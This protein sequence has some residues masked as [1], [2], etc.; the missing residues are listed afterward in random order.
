M[1]KSGKMVIIS[2]LTLGG[3]AASWMLYTSRFVDPK[4]AKPIIIAVSQTPL[5][6]PFL[7]ANDKQLFQKYG[8]DVV[9]QSCMGGIA[10]AQLLFEGQTDL[11]TASESVVMFESFMH[12]DIRLITSFVESDNDLKLLALNS[13]DIHE[14]DDL[15]EKRVGVV[16]GSA[17][18]FYFDSL[19]IAHNASDLNYTKIYMQPQDLLSALLS[20]KVDAISIWEPYGYKAMI[21]SKSEINNLG[22]QGIY[23]LSFNLIS[24]EK[25]IVQKEKELINLLLALQEAILWINSNPQESQALIAKSLDV[26]PNQLKWSWKDYLFRLS[27]GNVLLSNLQMQAR[28]ASEKG[29]VSGLTPD[30]RTVFYPLPLEQALNTRVQVK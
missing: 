18:E 11:A 9:L 17:S 3:V 19:L 12:R 5:S 7:V 23:Q 6:A 24:I 13:Q 25:N 29:L 20:F 2:L 16:E 1:V 15:R 4:L 26:P 21:S 27:L 28:W 10:C 22:L 8:V 14:I 30:F